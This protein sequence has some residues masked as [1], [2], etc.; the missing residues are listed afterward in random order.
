[1][2]VN[3]PEIASHAMLVVPKLWGTEFH[4]VNNDLYCMK[5]LK[6]LPGYQCSVHFHKKKDETFVGI[7]GTLALNLHDKDGKMIRTVSIEPGKTF[8]LVP[9]LVHS[10]QAINVTWV[11]EISTH[12]D[13]RDVFRLAESRKLAEK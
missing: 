10:F 9:K 12:H 1:M 3:E 13:D 4:I 6:I 7:S 8:R 2:I 11:Q 5:Y